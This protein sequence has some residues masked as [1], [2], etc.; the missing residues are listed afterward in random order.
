MGVRGMT[1]MLMAGP[2]EQ[3][4]VS[5]YPY[6]EVFNRNTAKEELFDKTAQ[7]NLAFMDELDS[8]SVIP[9]T[10]DE[11]A[12]LT[13]PYMERMNK[14]YDESGGDLSKMAAPMQKNV[15]EYYTGMTDAAKR[16]KKAGSSY[17]GQQAALAEGVKAGTFTQERASAMLAQQTQMYTKNLEAFKAGEIDKMP[18]GTEF[19]SSPVTTPDITEHMF[20]IQDLIQKN[21]TAQF[22][23]TPKYGLDGVTVV[24]YTDATT[25]REFTTEE[26]AQEVTSRF[27]S[28]LPE[29]DAW[30]DEAYTLGIAQQYNKDEH[31]SAYDLVSQEDPTL[32]PLS[33]NPEVAAYQM[34]AA[35]ATSPEQYNQ[36]LP[37]HQNMVRQQIAKQGEEQTAN[38]LWRERQKR[39]M[40]DDISAGSGISAVDRTSITGATGNTNGANNPN[41]DYT[42]DETYN[43]SQIPID[44]D[45]DNASGRVTNLEDYN[46][47]VAGKQSRIADLQS[48]IDSGTLSTEELQQAN[49]E[50][51]NITSDLGNLKKL[52]FPLTVNS[53]PGKSVTQ[54]LE[55]YEIFKKSFGNQIMGML[56][57][58][59]L[60]E[61]Q[62][63]NAGFEDEDDVGST[64]ALHADLKMISDYLAEYSEVDYDR[65]VANYSDEEAE[66][67]FG[68]TPV[69]PGILAV[70][71]DL[72][73]QFSRFNKLT[74][75]DREFSYNIPVADI[76]KIQY[77][78]GQIRS[79]DFLNNKL[80]F[81]DA[82]Q[83]EKNFH[84]LY[85][86]EIEAI[87]QK[88]SGIYQD[89]EG[90]QTTSTWAPQLYVGEGLFEGKPYF[91]MDPK[92]YKIG[93]KAPMPLPTNLVETDIFE[94]KIITMDDSK[95]MEAY[96]SLASSYIKKGKLLQSTGDVQGASEK[97]DQGIQMQLNARYL[98]MLQAS[99]IETAT[100]TIQ[101]ADGDEYEYRVLDPTM[102]GSGVLS[103]KDGGTVFDP[104]TDEIRIERK[105]IMPPVNV[106]S[107]E[108][109]TAEPTFSS[110]Y[111]YFY[112]PGEGEGKNLSIEKNKSYLDFEN[113][114]HEAPSLES[115][116]FRAF[117]GENMRQQALSG[118]QPL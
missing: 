1:G 99:G 69:H 58:D 21:Q 51:G 61:Y 47:E 54:A 12:V 87:K 112:K 53:L 64:G 44:N 113:G 40:I 63:F 117:G 57:K 85:K 66:R 49:E 105:R 35:G 8:Y 118:N 107:E 110:Y 92:F 45:M 90:L 56:D 93:G 17:Q 76:S 28:S 96:N 33:D 116:I 97:F 36:N 29:Y 94:K 26:G 25:T 104:A 50:M 88:V 91:V 5:P 43:T 86:K 6:Q 71:K 77:D 38:H 4:T 103:N 9:G 15:Y 52:E 100:S 115:L 34:Y 74:D 60:A 95:A 2:M 102:F 62:V 89:E 70:G 68:R 109:P 65:L 46:Q 42:Q 80:L 41:F 59:A 75:V 83:P 84:E 98:P 32:L 39:S 114:E 108:Q 3:T 30:T 55:N 48:A 81:K 67:L 31:G 101:T 10:E 106:D 23:L 111:I 82:L 20:K 27:L 7:S 18:Q 19:N 79:G 22:G 16:L 78:R 73:E 13:A 72:N 11:A 14:L 24:G 37:I